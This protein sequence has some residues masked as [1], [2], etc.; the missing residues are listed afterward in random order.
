MNR[1]LIFA[2]AAIPM[3][4]DASL[5]GAALLVLAG[6]CVLVMRRASASARHMV[7]LAAMVALLIVPVLSVVLP[8][9]RV[10]PRWSARDAVVAEAVVPR[11]IEKPAQTALPMERPTV[12]PAV[13]PLPVPEAVPV[14]RPNVPVAVAKE[15]V[16]PILHYGWL[17]PIWAV[18]CAV[19]VLRLAAAHVLLRRSTRR[20]IRRGWR[21]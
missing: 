6:G 12:F 1:V 9:W 19:L 21:F 14:L 8:G 13:P 7:W 4:A 5:K 11:A 18:G 15:S 10:L 16:M 3:L 17:L 20:C 2:A